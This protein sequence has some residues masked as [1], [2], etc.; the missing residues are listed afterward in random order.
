[1]KPR[2]TPTPN[3][4]CEHAAYTL[5]EL[6]AVMFMVAITAIAGKSV[7]ARYGTWAGVGAGFIAALSSVCLVALFYR[8][9]WQRDRRRL[10]ELKEKY[11]GIYR[12]IRLPSS[13]ASII[14]PQGAE[15]KIGDY[16]WEAGPDRSDGLIY[17]HGLAPDWTV[18]WH[19][20]FRPEEVE[21][22]AE[23]PTSQY[24]YWAPYWTKSPPPP[25]CPFPV[26]ERETMTW[27]RPHHSHRYFQIPA[28]YRLEPK[29]RT[30]PAKPANQSQ[31]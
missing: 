17:L 30:D 25:P 7:A 2:R 24:D 21:R 14:K 20:G 28:L 11:R 22:V 12:V 27:G 23:K 16:G 4:K 13:D 9:S 18:V 15:A 10:E 3:N 5:I 31:G 29:G 8:W 26:T 6:L 19:I 1:M